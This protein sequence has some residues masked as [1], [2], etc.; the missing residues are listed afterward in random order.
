MKCVAFTALLIRGYIALGEP[1]LN[2][3]PGFTI[4]RVAGQP[5]ISFHLYA[6]GHT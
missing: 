3:P 2:V 4:E 6:N 1:T 5:E